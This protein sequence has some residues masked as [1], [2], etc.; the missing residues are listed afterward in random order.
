MS[1]SDSCPT[2]TFHYTFPFPAVHSAQRVCGS[3]FVHMI[4]F[5]RAV[6][7][8]DAMEQVCA[9]RCHVLLSQGVASTAAPK[10]VHPANRVLDLSVKGCTRGLLL[11]WFHL[12]GAMSACPFLIHA[13]TKHPIIHCLFLL[14]IRRASA[15]KSM[16]NP[17]VRSPSGLSRQLQ[18]HRFERRRNVDGRI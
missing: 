12:S 6:F 17:I 11:A 2:K 9:F 1:S 13:Q 18:I 14:Y 3:A 16:I 10:S 8:I 5:P 15:A 7:L 4:D